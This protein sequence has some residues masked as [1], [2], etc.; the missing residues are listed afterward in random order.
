[1]AV[2]CCA[3]PKIELLKYVCHSIERNETIQLWYKYYTFQ[4]N[5][6]SASVFEHMSSNSNNNNNNK[7]R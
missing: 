3:I 2:Y 6:I 7:L 5:L 4:K 1:M